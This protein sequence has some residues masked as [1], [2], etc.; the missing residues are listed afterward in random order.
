MDPFEYGDP[1]IDWN[2]E[3]SAREVPEYDEYCNNCGSKSCSRN[4]PER[5]IEDPPDED[6][7][8]LL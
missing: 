6:G 2:E 1:Y 3:N 8:F 7:T 5:P 4:C